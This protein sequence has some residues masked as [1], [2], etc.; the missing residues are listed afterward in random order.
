MVVVVVQE[1]DDIKV[2]N[3]RRFCFVPAPADGD[4]KRGVWNID[5]ELLTQP[6]QPLH[7]R[8]PL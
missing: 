2:Y 4:D 8:S 6:L 7:F 5:G 3:V 1:E